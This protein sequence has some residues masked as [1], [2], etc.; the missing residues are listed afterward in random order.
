M[1][2]W[3]RAL[4]S[5]AV[6]PAAFGAGVYAWTAPAAPADGLLPEAKP[7]P[8]QLAVNPCSPCNPCNPCSPAKN[9]CSP[10]NPCNP[11]SPSAGAPVNPC[12]PGANK[13]DALS[14]ACTVPRL[15]ASPAPDSADGEAP[16]LTPE[17]ALAAYACLKSEMRRA[18]ARS[19]W[20]DAGA[21]QSWWRASAQ[22]Y[23]SSTHG[24]RYVSNYAGDLGDFRYKK[25]EDAGTMPPGSVLAKDSFTV[26]ADGALAV[27]PLF[28]M[29]K[30][31]SRFRAATGNWRYLTVLPDGSVYGDSHGDAAA[32]VEFC[33]DCHAAAAETD[34][35]YFLP[36]DVRAGK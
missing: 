15:T 21:Y 4:L 2:G 17:E 22:P 25:F 20:N 11:C 6:I 12:S 23:A 31:G 9:P 33:N 18:Y 29:E 28:V 5:G 8:A 32:T 36:D 30:M 10:C 13:A 19:G 7:R 27:G 24:E 34:Y 14:R 1:K 35:L 26:R 3:R 16:A